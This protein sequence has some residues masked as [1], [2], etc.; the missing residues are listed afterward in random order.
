MDK[1]VLAFA[2]AALLSGGIASAQTTTV[3]FETEGDITETKSVAGHQ[4]TSQSF[5]ERVTITFTAN[6]IDSL[7]PDSNVRGLGIENTDPVS[8]GEIESCNE[9]RNLSIGVAGGPAGSTKSTSNP[10]ICFSETLAPFDGNVDFAGT[11]GASQPNATNV[12]INASETYTG[13]DAAFFTSGGF[14]AVFEFDG[15]GSGSNETA[16]AQFANG[17]DANAS[18]QVVYACK[19]ACQFDPSI[20][21]DDPACEAP[22]EPCPF[23]PS[24]TADDPACVPPPAVPGITNMGLIGALIG[25]PLIAGFF[26]ARRR[27]K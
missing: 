1:R 2:A 23:D 16:D 22:P 17:L 25:L 20:P 8:S 26:A 6:A 24:L 19:N 7:I 10:E 14:D 12:S 21:A 5:L 4:C 11:S 9:V 3:S 18:L 27:M 13:A 15:R